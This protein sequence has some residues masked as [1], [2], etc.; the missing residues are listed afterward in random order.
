ME[1]DELEVTYTPP[2]GSNTS[3]AG[4][5]E[6][7]IKTLNRR[8]QYVRAVTNETDKVGSQKRIA[9]IVKEFA[10]KIG[11]ASPP[12]ISTVAGWIKRWIDGGRTDSA[13]LSATKPS[14]AQFDED[15]DLHRIIMAAIKKVYMNRQK[16]SI[17][18]VVME[19]AVRVAE[20]NCYAESPLK[21]PSAETIRRYINR[22]DAYQL[23]VA[24]HGKAYANRRHRAAGRGF[25]TTEALELAMA[26][27]QMM[28]IIVVE[29]DENGDPGA[30]IGRPF[31]TAVFDVHTR[32]VLAAEVTLAPFCGGTLLKAMRQACVADPRKPRGV[33]ST[34]IVDNGA[35]YQDSGFIAA[36][37]KIGTILE[38]CPPFMPNA[39]AHMER[40]FGTFNKQ[41]A[42]KFPG[43][44]FSNPV[45]KGDYHSQD[46]ARIT[47]RELRLHVETWIDEIYHTNLH[48][49]LG[50]APIDVWNEATA[51][52]PPQTIDE[53]DADII[54]RT[55]ESRTISNGRVQVHDLM[56]YSHALRS[57]EVRQRQLG[58]KPEVDVQVDELDLGYV[59]VRLPD[60]DGTIIKAE[61]T[62]PQYTRN[63]SLYEH[64]LLKEETKK[65]GIK[66]RFE[67]MK[68]AE[69][70]R[71]RLEYFAALGHAKDTVARVRRD[72]LRDALAARHPETPALRG[73][74]NTS[75]QA[76]APPTDSST[77][78]D[79]APT[80]QSS[81]PEQ[82]STQPPPTEEEPNH[83]T[84]TSIPEKPETPKTP[85]EKTGFPVRKNVQRI[86]T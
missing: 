32:C 34:L 84:G 21:T 45:D 69:L 37:N 58:R 7:Q 35:D 18:A 11:D 54:F 44:T 79:A 68:D 23:D 25:Y 16:N 28:D 20:H 61:S 10:K 17:A 53:A 77:D 14:R 30:D 38:I 49:S 48:R 47:L 76:I 29:E 12:G 43:T 33:P 83:K 66:E 65:K 4:L 75:G 22:I 50:R 26:D 42:H 72:R 60:N 27:G 73:D 55:T 5:T 67:R 41:L 80:R 13:L 46:T 19:V 40:F 6:A 56:W 81:K 63:L 51:Q 78:A 3:R 85:A 59:Y 1:S 86:K 2:V 70:Y 62:Q 8:L 57:W 71:L 64:R 36:T 15:D 9:V 52:T 24:R 82:D 31:L 39:K 74:Q